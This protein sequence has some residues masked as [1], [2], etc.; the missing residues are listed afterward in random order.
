[1]RATVT[2]TLPPLPHTP[3]LQIL[4]MGGTQKPG[5]GTANN[6]QV[7]AVLDVGWEARQGAVRLSPADAPRVRVPV[8]RLRPGTLR[9]LG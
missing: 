4:I 5:A 3:S 9:I 7:W 6:P 8:R 1:M 2:I